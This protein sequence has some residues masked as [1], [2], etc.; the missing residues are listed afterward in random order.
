MTE[1]ND[2]LMPKNGPGRPKGATGSAKSKSEQRF[3]KFMDGRGADLD[4]VL[5]QVLEMAAQ[6]DVQC[7]KI[8]AERVWPARGRTVRLNLSGDLTTAADRVL[9][10]MDA[11]DITPQE[12]NEALGVLA[13]RDEIAQTQLFEQRLALL[14]AQED[15]QDGH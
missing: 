7:I 10:A 4:R 9:K 15:A 3:H 14:E 1:S 11:G 2:D 5:S 12:A 8:V 6:G 13:K